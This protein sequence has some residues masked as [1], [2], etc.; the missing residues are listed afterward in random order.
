VAFENVGMGYLIKDG[1]KPTEAGAKA[2]ASNPALLETWLA[3]VTTLDGQPALPA[4]KAK[5]G[6]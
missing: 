1:M 6:L 5:L 3:G 4:V 2:I